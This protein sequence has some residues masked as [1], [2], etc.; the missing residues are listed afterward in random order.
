MSDSTKI[1]SIYEDIAHWYDRNRSKNLFEKDY[2]DALING[3]MEVDV[4][5]L[6]CGP[7]VPIANYI[8][9]K[10]HRVTGIDSSETMIAICRSRFP[11]MQWLQQDMRETELERRF[12]AIIAWDSFFHLSHDDQRSMFPVFA[13]HAKPECRLLF[14]SGPEYGEAFGEM[15]GHTVYHASL[16]ADE[17]RLLL[18]A[19][20]FQVIKHAINDPECGGHTIWLAEYI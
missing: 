9:E 12:E 6:G 1:I 18:E 14:T 19:H 4:L 15:S 13:R 7:G 3:R 16:S 10:G 20:G 2:L 17:Y 5:D 8:I 11:H